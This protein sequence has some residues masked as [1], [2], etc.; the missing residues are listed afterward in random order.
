MMRM[1]V[2]AAVSALGLVA[3]AG[4]YAAPV[5]IVAPGG[6]DDAIVLVQDSQQ[7]KVSVKSAVLRAQPDPK[8][9]KIASL[10]RGSRVQ[11]IDTSSGDWVH[12]R[13]GKREG[14]VSKNLLSMGG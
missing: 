12:V 2:F 11:V 5:G 9:K 10:R 6:Q 13:S 14:Y 3:A 4:A 7:A 8:S 1:K